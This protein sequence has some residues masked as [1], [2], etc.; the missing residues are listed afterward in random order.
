MVRDQKQDARLPILVLSLLPE[1]L[2]ALG[3]KFRLR[4]QLDVAEP[5]NVIRTHRRK[6][7]DLGDAIGNATLAVERPH[8][9]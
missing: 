2:V 6:G 4:L 5:Y 7:V 3:G 1:D 9:Q 8:S